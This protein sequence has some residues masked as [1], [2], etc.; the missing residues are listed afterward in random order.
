MVDLPGPRGTL[1]TPSPALDARL[2]V[3]AGTEE[4][5]PLETEPAGSNGPLL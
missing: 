5:V 2:H 4:G 1:T 3:N